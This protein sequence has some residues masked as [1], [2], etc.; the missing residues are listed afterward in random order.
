MSPMQADSQV[1]V[2]VI[3]YNRC[4]ELAGSLTRLRSLPERPAIVVVD[5]GSADETTAMVRDRYPDVTLVALASNLGAVGRNI[6]VALTSTPFVAFCDD[7]TWWS[8]GSLAEAVDLLTRHPRLAVV[9]A[10]I[11]VEPEG[12]LDPVSDEMGRSPLPCPPDAPGSPLLSFLAGASVVRRRAF[13]AV[14]GFSPRI[15]IGG[16]E[17]LL[18]ADLADAGWAMAYVPQ[19][20]IHH[21]ASVLRNPHLRRRQGIRNTLWFTWLRRPLTSALLRTGVILGTIPRDRHSLAAVVETA[22]GATWVAAQR[23]VVGAE[24]EKGLRLLDR[25]LRTSEARQYVS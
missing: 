19:L 2:V 3:T 25:D 16:E 20:T 11:V 1:S 8:P 22:R 18:A 23:R 10:S 13:L 14:G 17:E 15:R 4:E 21:R 24:V 5:N 7:D 12:Y 9:T 6:G